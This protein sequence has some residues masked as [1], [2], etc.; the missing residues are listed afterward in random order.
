LG[1]GRQVYLKERFQPPRERSGAMRLPLEGTLCSARSASPRSAR[2]RPTGRSRADARSR[3][4]PVNSSGGARPLR[5]RAVTHLSRLSSWTARC[6]QNVA[7]ECLRHAR[8]NSPHANLAWAQ[9]LRGVPP[10]GASS[11]AVSPSTVRPI[12][13]ITTAL[14]A[15]NL[16]CQTLWDIA[17][18][19]DPSARD[20]CRRQP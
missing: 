13:V 18:L 12:A 19:P 16:A 9:Q 7:H 15:C 2:A 5:R 4:A 1:R 17:P 8:T 14:G 20:P 10:S 6:A 11:R 3:T